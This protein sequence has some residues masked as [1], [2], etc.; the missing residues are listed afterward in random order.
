M[1]A[2]GEPD[3]AGGEGGGVGGEDAGGA[4]AVSV[5]A[6][7]DAHQG[8]GEVVGDVEGEGELG[9]ATLLWP[10]RKS[11][12]ARRMSRVAAQLPSSKAEAPTQRRRT[13]RRSRA[14]GHRRAGY[15]LVA[16]RGPSVA[17]AAATRAC[18]FRKMGPE[19]VTRSR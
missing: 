14:G 16:C 18:L 10:A 2:D 19:V 8:G 15:E 1:G 9:G 5:A 3:V 12:V 11:S 13:R 4:V 7:R 17:T 6:G